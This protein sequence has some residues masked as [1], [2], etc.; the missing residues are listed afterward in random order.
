MKT[1]TGKTSTLEVEPSHT[2]EKIRKV[3]SL[4]SNAQLEDGILNYVGV[5]GTRLWM[6]S[7]LYKNS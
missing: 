3:S 6:K 2:I 7:F 5:A 4:T 1:L